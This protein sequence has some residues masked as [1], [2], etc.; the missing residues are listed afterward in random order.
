MPPPVLLLIFGSLLGGFSFDS[1]LGGLSLNIEDLLGEFTANLGD[2]VQD[3]YNNIYSD[4][5]AH[6][7]LWDSQ[8]RQNLFELFNY[9][10]G[11]Y[12][13]L[14]GAAFLIVGLLYI[15]QLLPLGALSLIT[16]LFHPLLSRLLAVILRH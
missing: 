14:P 10:E 9:L 7:E 5:A 11:H 1:V 8:E 6:N 2:S 16:L 4:I 15:L 12:L 3:Q 13:L